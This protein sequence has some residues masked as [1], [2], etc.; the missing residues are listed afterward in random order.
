MA[1][2]KYFNYVF[3]QSGDKSA[4]PDIAPLDG[5][6]S[7]QSGWGPFYAL[8]LGVDPD[9][10]PIPRPQSNQLAFDMTTAIQQYQQIGIPN[11]ILSSQTDGA[12]PFP[13][14][15][16]SWCI[17]D[18][19]D[20]NGPQPYQS[21]V[22]ANV[23]T[24]PSS[25]WQ[26]M[27]YPVSGTLLQ[28]AKYTWVADTGAANAIIALLTPAVIALVPGMRFSVKI[29]ATNT[30]PTTIVVNA[31]G[32]VNVSKRTV[33]GL[34]ALVGQELLINVTYDF[35][36]DGT[37]FEVL[38]PSD[39][40]TYSSGVY[41]DGTGSPY[42]LPNLTATP[43]IFNQVD[44][45]D[46]YGVITQLVS[47]SPVNTFT[48]NKSGRYQLTGNIFTAFG[49]DGTMQID[50]YIN[51]VDAFRICE[52]YGHD[53][54]DILSDNFS[55]ELSLTSGQYIQLYATPHLSSSD[56]TLLGSTNGE[57]TV[58]QLKYVGN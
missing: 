18:I 3:G 47:S 36:Y 33:L 28:D 21:L 31:L 44:R 42:T 55:V 41:Y 7:Y 53:P 56:A 22:N 50:I 14:A 27:T 38:N 29:I 19:L 34:A 49:A 45:V 16:W 52:I 1:A 46:P 58:F 35:L 23:T 24:P 17:Y 37:V 15:K 5:S 8:Q 2:T 25:S 40:I 48:V 57:F 43:L 6:V 26:L 32:A 30:G 13:Y 11:F 4:I 51:G 10:L 20:G 9:A 54:A 39:L 12:G